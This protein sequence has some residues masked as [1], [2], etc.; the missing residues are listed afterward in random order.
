MGHITLPNLMIEVIMVFG[1]E[2]LDIDEWD[3]EPQEQNSYCDCGIELNLSI[4]KTIS[5]SPALK[6]KTHQSAPN[7]RYKVERMHTTSCMSKSSHVD[8]C[9]SPFFSPSHL[10]FCLC[11]T[12]PKCPK[13]FFVFL[14]NVP[15]C[16]WTNFPFQLAAVL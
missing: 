6:L 7:N 15:V 13:S 8:Y 9:P 3:I 11:T 12:P 10:L 1:F 14:L 4:L 2:H 5:S 16:I